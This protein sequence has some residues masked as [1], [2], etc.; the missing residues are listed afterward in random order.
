MDDFQFKNLKEF[1][2]DSIR[3]S[4]QYFELDHLLNNNNDEKKEQEEKDHIMIDIDCFDVKLN[5]I[6]TEQMNVLKEI[7]STET[8]Y[9]SF[10]Q[11][12]VK[13]INRL[14]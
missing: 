4:L 7:L 12:T 5:K 11:E 10:L 3:K 13:V 1:N 6:E 8:K 9:L 14:N 2:N